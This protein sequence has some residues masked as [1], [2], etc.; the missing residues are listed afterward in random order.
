MTGWRLGYLAAPEWIAKAA[1]KIQGQFT[2]GTCNFN[3]HAAIAALNGDMQ[4]TKDMTAS[5]LMRRDMM[6][7]LLKP[8]TDFQFSVPDGAFYLF[9]DVSR[10]FGKTIQGVTLNSADD[11]VEFLLDKAH[12]ATV[13]GTAFGDS[14]CI[15]LSIATSK[16][17]LREAA[18]RLLKLFI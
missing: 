9:P 12:I 11:V 8:L 15:R 4:P 5:Y 6:I 16:D 3:Q 13:T 14:N 2:S 10:L 7:D 17:K 18:E 1:A